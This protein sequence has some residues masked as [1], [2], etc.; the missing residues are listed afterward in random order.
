MNPKCVGPSGVGHA[1]RHQN[2]HRHRPTPAS[3]E[4]FTNFRQL[5]FFHARLLSEYQNQYFNDS[6]SESP[7]YIHSP[8]HNRAALNMAN[9]WNPRYAEHEYDLTR[10]CL[11]RV[12]RDWDDLSGA[13]RATAALFGYSKKGWDDEL[14][15]AAIPWWTDEKN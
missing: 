15:R 5:L 11:D 4:N 6:V 13:D 9:E 3:A 10:F 8:Q 14:G 12:F 7:R 2:F 1:L